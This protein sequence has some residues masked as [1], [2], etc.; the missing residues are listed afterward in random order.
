MV[1]QPVMRVDVVTDD[2]GYCK[3]SIWGTRNYYLGSCKYI[4]MITV[5]RGADSYAE[6]GSEESWFSG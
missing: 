6:D 1:P 2:N 3:N 4:Y 5:M